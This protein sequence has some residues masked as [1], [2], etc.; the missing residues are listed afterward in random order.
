ML[1]ARLHHRH[2]DVIGVRLHRNRPKTRTSPADTGPSRRRKRKSKLVSGE[3]ALQA[4]PDG[5]C[6]QWPQHL[7]GMPRTV[8]MASI[9]WKVVDRQIRYLHF[10]LRAA[11]RSRGVGRTEDGPAARGH[12]VSV[13]R[14][15]FGDLSLWLALE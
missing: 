15:D 14:Q 7:S 13:E 10:S 4:L 9:V 11:G 5:G 3:R 12:P 2:R 1:D 6:N 8:S